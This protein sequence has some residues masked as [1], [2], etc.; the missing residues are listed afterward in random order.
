MKSR[1]PLEIF[2]RSRSVAGSTVS[3]HGFEKCKV[4]PRIPGASSVLSL[5]NQST[6]IR[7]IAI[8]L[9]INTSVMPFPI[10]PCGSMVTC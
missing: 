9:L 8:M 10:I 4:M 3:N 2:T 7:Y 1:S 5:R 6:S